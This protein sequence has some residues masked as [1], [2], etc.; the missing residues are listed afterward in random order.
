MPCGPSETM[1]DG[2][3]RRS[4]PTVHQNDEPLVSAAFSFEGEVT[5]EP[6]DVECHSAILAPPARR[7]SAGGCG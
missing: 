5:D 3:P 6:V 1:I 4:T 2:M 7:V